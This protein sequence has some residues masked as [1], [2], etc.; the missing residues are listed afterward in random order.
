M[1]TMTIIAGSFPRSSVNYF[2]I[3]KKD[4]SSILEYRFYDGMLKVRYFLLFGPNFYKVLANFNFP[5]AYV[6]L[7]T[8]ISLFVDGGTSS[9]FLSTLCW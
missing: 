4:D 6:P 5:D 1:M 3:S 9:T 7:I 8:K 2:S